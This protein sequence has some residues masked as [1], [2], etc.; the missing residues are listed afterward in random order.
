[1]RMPRGIVL[2][3]NRPPGG[4]AWEKKMQP[5][6]GRV[7][8]IRAETHMSFG[9]ARLVEY[10]WDEPLDVV[11]PPPKN[12]RIDYALTP[13][14]KTRGACFPRRW[15]SQ[16][17]EA[18]G[19]LFILPPDQPMHVRGICGRHSS[20][21]CELDPAAVH[22]WLDEDITWTAPRLRA[23]L[24]INSALI[25]NTLLRLRDE[26][27]KPGFAAPALCEALAMQTAIEIAHFCRAIQ[28][29][30]PAGGLASWRLRLIEERTAE[31][32]P[33][34]RL[35]ELA[36]LC[37]I[38]VRQMTRGFRE[39]RHCSLGDYIAERRLDQAK[40]RL[41]GDIS[42]KEVA[43]SLGFAS[44][45]NFSNA[46]RRATGKCPRQYRQSMRSK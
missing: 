18:L 38:S 3:S 9:T 6:G 15:S 22:N 1:M 8:T 19:Q 34:P 4:D 21:V 11:G 17:F 33:P 40:L 7:A 36:D 20:V 13:R 45:T 44:P 24:D 42:V 32:G 39:S 16:Q 37:N 46:F 28:Q 25:R 31:A 26:L 10:S 27:L 12:Y 14:P 30:K 29:S 5:E 41:S 35:S 43:F 23:C 2:A